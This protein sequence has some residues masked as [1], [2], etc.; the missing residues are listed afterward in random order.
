VRTLLEKID[1]TLQEVGS[2]AYSSALYIYSLAKMHKN[3]AE[4]ADETM[5]DLG[6][7]FLKKSLSNKE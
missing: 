3:L 4:L 6:K 7:R 2:E 1:D 5:D